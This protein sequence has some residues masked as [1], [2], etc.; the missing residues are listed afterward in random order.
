MPTLLVNQ[1]MD[2][3]L[4]ARIQASLAGSSK[5]VSSARLVALLRLGAVLAMA[6]VGG[7]MLLAQRHEHSELEQTRAAL[8]GTW[9]AQALPITPK[10]REFL[11]RTERTLASFAGAYP[12]DQI[13]PGVPGVTLAQILARPSIYIRGPAEAF[14]TPEGIARAA[15]DSDKDTLLLC[16]LDPPASRDE[17]LLLVTARL[18]LAAGVP[19]QQL[20]P[21]V[22]RLRDVVEGLPF[23]LPPWAERVRNAPRLPELLR[24]ERELKRAPIAGAKSA[25]RAELLIAVL[26]EPNDPGGVTELDGEHSHQVRIMVRELA[27]EKLLLRLRR[28]VAPDWIT[29]SR[30]AKYA[31]E[32]DGCKFALDV[33]DATRASGNLPAP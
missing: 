5:G 2:P 10:E 7:A 24:L 28:Q 8:L 21:N 33:H 18:T 30:R 11:G 27:T 12:G 22:R 15:S 26:D 32:L 17:K 4:R 25:L 3:A 1:K 9:S 13:A 19:F 6:T 23:L 29:Q 20:A 31:R 16:L 14:K